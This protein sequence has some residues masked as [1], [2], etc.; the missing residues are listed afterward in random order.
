M[1]GI[2]TII[3]TLFAS[4]FLTAQ[5]TSKSSE[6]DIKITNISKKLHFFEGY[7]YE[8]NNK[9]GVKIN[10]YISNE[11]IRKTEKLKKK[12][13]FFEVNLNYLES[14]ILDERSITLVFL[15]NS[16]VNKSGAKSNEIK[17]NF[18]Y[19]KKGDYIWS[20]CDTIVEEMQK[21]FQYLADIAKEKREKD[22]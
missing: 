21:A 4:S 3:I 12:D 6:W 16:V 10:Y 14:V 17:L 11:K 9:N 8:N 2:F 15:K 19:S 22:I 5:E 20:K 1:K 13:D 18:L 7:S